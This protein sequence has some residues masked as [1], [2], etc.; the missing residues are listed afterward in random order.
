MCR[1]ISS[2]LIS[3]S[4]LLSVFIV[5]LA[6]GTHAD[7]PQFRV[8]SFIPEKFVDMQLFVSGNFNLSGNDN[9]SDVIYNTEGDQPDRQT[10]NNS[11]RQSVS[12]STQLRTRYETIPKYFHSGS[13]LRFKFNNSDRSSSRSY[14]KDFDYSNFEIIDQDEHNYEIKKAPRNR[15]N[16]IATATL[17]THTN[18]LISV[19]HYIITTIQWRITISTPNCCTGMAAYTTVS[20]PQPPCI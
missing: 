10:E 2:S 12:L 1:I 8:N 13:N 6:I 15:M 20:M 14:I 11:D 16:W 7:E 3:S 19:I 9:N 17:M 18:S 4:L 5:V